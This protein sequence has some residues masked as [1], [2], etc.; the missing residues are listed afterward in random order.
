MPKYIFIDI[1]GVFHDGDT[2]P[3]CGASSLWRVI[4]PFDVALIVHSS[5]RHSMELDAIR[6]AFPI[7]MRRYIVDATVG[8]DPFES[9][10]NYVSQHRVSAF[11]VLDDCWERFPTSWID[12]GILL[13]CRPGSGVSDPDIRERIKRFLVAPDPTTS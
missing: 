4:A 7:E 12:S 11:I 10:L 1:D 2:Q 8:K 6:N 3:V 13:P 5:W 9:I